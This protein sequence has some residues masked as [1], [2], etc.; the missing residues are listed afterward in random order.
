MS[1]T[2][3]PLQREDVR[4]SQ[5]QQEKQTLMKSGSNTDTSIG[6]LRMLHTPLLILPIAFLQEIG[7]RLIHVLVSSVV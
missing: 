1:A 4:D 5:S 7:M 2:M 6:E 3:A